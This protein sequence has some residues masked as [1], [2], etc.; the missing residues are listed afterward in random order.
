MKINILL[1]LYF[2]IRYFTIMI[3][4]LLIVGTYKIESYGIVMLLY[5]IAINYLAVKYGIIYE[6]DKRDDL[7]KN[8][9]SKSI[10]LF[11]LLINIV[12]YF[13]YKFKLSEVVILSVIPVI[14][15][16]LIKTKKDKQ[17]IIDMNTKKTID[18]YFKNKK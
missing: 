4:V 10:I 17:R 9:L 11:L 16:Y 18:E 14:E 3:F 7:D 15:F 1:S 12:L 6:I 13:L 8:D 5:Y 2:T